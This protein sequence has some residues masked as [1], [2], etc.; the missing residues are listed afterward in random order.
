MDLGLICLQPS[1]K[2]NLK[3]FVRKSVNLDQFKYLNCTEK[4]ILMCIS[5]WQ[6][7]YISHHAFEQRKL[8]A[9]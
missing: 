1:I 4:L 8:K 2:L 9:L 3:K 6:N 5:S 7:L